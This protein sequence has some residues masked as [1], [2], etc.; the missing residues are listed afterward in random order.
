MQGLAA[1]EDMQPRDAQVQARRQQIAKQ[2]TDYRRFL[3]RSLRLLNPH[4]YANSF[5]TAPQFRVESPR[6]ILSQTPSRNGALR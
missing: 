4:A 3:R 5:T 1:I 6:I 2:L